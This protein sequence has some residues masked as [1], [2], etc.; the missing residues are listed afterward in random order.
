MIFVNFKTYR[1]G[2]GEAAIKL[3]Q[4]CQA[5]EKKTSVKIFPVVQTADIFRIVKETNG[6]VWA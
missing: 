3:I 1:Q 4:I 2:T 5:V 6:P